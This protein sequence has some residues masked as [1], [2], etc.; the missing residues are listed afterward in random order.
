MSSPKT[1]AFFGATIGCGLATLSNALD[2]DTRCIALCRTPS[3]LEGLFSEDKTSRLT[4]VEGN[5]HDVD[6]VKKCLTVDGTHLVDTIIFS[7]GSRSMNYK[8]EL[9]DPSI[10]RRAI[11]TVLIA[12]STTGISQF[13]PDTPYIVGL[14][15]YYLLYSPHEDKKAM[16][17]LI[18]GSD[19]DFTIVRSSWMLDGATNKAVRV[20]VE[21]P[22]NGR[23]S[24]AIGYS[25]TREDVGKWI[26]ENLVQNDNG[27]YV[28]KIA[29]ITH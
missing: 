16:E 3:K 29:T 25:I 27:L 12:L 1:I 7:I 4:I 21:D 5:V 11:A 17:Q 23:E 26:F 13:G 22:K 28:R 15:Y 14:L 2:A 6:A 19:E 9:D 24:D 8:L 20:G 18:V 10:C